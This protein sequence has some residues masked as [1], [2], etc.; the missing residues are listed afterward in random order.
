MQPC[1]HSYAVYP[2]FAAALTFASDFRT[3]NRACFRNLMTLNRSKSV[4]ARLRSFWA[5]FFAHAL[6]CHFS[7]IPAFSHAFLTAPVRA[8]RGNFSRTKG[9]RMQ[10]ARAIDWR[11]TA[12]FVSVD[13]PS[14]RAWFLLLLRPFLLFLKENYVRACGQWSLQWQQAFHLEGHRG[15]G[16]HVQ[17]QPVS[18]MMLWFRRHPL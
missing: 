14:T 3:S 17:P 2:Y 1:S 9:V 5:R 12:V 15:W 16:Q 13:G 11:G 7:S 8:P 10:C 18:R 6:S 4:R